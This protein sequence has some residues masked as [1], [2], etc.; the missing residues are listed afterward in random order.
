MAGRTK[1]E[2]TQNPNPN[3]HP[4]PNPNPN[5]SDDDLPVPEFL[6]IE[7]I[8]D[9]L[10]SYLYSLDKAIVGKDKATKDVRRA[11]FRRKFGDDVGSFSDEQL[12]ILEEAEKTYF[13]G[14]MYY[15]LTQN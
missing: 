8:N 1:G 2:T 10:D 5:H 14:K 6:K 11:V 4:H 13:K 15:R 3:P 7:R 12:L 9:R